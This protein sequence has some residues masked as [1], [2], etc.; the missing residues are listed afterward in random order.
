MSDTEEI[1]RNKIKHIFSNSILKCLDNLDES[2]KKL[3]PWAN[4]SYTNQQFADLIADEIDKGIIN[5][6]IKQ[7]CSTFDVNVYR[8]KAR[9]LKLNLLPNKQVYCI[10][11]NKIHQDSQYNFSQTHHTIPI[12]PP[13]LDRYFKKEI[14]MKFI[15]EDATHQDLYPERYSE[16]EYLI[17][18]EFERKYYFDNYLNRPDGAVQCWKCKSWKTEYNEKQLRSADEPTTKF[19]YCWKCKNRWKFS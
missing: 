5:Y 18:S 13:I 6:M 11:Y 2:Q 1:V 14:T 17:H 10:E 7:R 3:Y 4:L 12:F 8:N 16:I 15:C 9:M 19:A